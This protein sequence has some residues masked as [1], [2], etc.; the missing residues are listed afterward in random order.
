MTPTSDLYPDP[1]RRQPPSHVRLCCEHCGAAHLHPTETPGPV[2]R[3]AP[4]RGCVIATV[5][6]LALWA[7]AASA[8]ALWG[9]WVKVP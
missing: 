3:L 6:A 1:A 8:F 7:V 2:E 4:S 5:I 9:V